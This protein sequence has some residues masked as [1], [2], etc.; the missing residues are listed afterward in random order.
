MTPRLRLLYLLFMLGIGLLARCTSPSEP[1]ADGGTHTGNPDISAAASVVFQLA[2]LD[3]AWHIDGYL[4]PE[5]LNPEKAA[6]GALHSV[7]G[8]V[9]GLG[10]RAADSGDVYIWVDTIV[11]ADT[12][13]RYDTLL[14]I[15]TVLDTSFIVSD[16]LDTLIGSDSVRYISD[17]LAH[18]TVVAIDTV[19]LTDT[20]FHTDTLLVTD[21]ISVGEG[22]AAPPVPGDGTNLTIVNGK[23]GYA[24]EPRYDST[25]FERGDT[26]FKYYF[27]GYARQ[28]YLSSPAD[29]VVYTGTKGAYALR[30]SYV[31][32]DMAVWLHY[33]DEDGD[34]YLYPLQGGA[35]AVIGL[36]E[37][38]ARN[39]SRQILQG[40]FDQGKDG[41][42][43]T[44]ADNRLYHMRRVLVTNGDTVESVAYSTDEQQSDTLTVTLLETDPSDTVFVS[45]T[46]FA[47]L[48]GAARRLSHDDRLGA[49]GRV[50]KF[51]FS[52]YTER[53]V[54][55][56]DAVL[57]PSVSLSPAERFK[58]TEFRVT[59]HYFS[60]D[61]AIFTGRYDA[62]EGISGSFVRGDQVT[63]IQFEPPKK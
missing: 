13:Y 46:R 31:N 29:E 58:K 1:V 16:T 41:H 19:I 59:V 57:L 34:G 36:T 3:T 4:P 61:T 27:P 54:K 8:T 11:L 51:R 40:T 10:K 23:T 26:T 50:V 9:G 56:I 62:Q 60:G 48:P 22:A 25:G 20:I 47:V 44:S 7:P 15:D 42:P 63:E 38:R 18:E 6:P 39:Q 24:N 5:Y 53:A 43:S 14:E 45:R 32:G 12:S 52:P 30:K 28:E 21:T 55:Q 33:Y 35:D 2:S 49:V 17:S 37:H